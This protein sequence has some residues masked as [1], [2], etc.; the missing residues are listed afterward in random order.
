MVAS[1]SPIVAW[2]QGARVKLQ[3][4]GDAWSGPLKLTKAGGKLFVRLAGGAANPGLSITVVS[5]T[6]VRLGGR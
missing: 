6:P 5:P 3:Q 4:Q 2:E 1:K